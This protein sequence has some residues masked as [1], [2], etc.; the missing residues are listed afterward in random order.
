MKVLYRNMEMWDWG[1][2]ESQG[3]I[4]DWAVFQTEVRPEAKGV[5]TF[6]ER[7]VVKR[8]ERN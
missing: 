2:G 5:G 8:E 4:M 3:W 7:K 1:V 6:S